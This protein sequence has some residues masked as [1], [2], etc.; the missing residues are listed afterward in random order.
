VRTVTLPVVLSPLFV[1]VALTLGLFCWMAYQRVTSIRS[2]TVHPRDIALREPN[3]PKHCLQVANAA[4][5]QLETPVLFY[6]LTILA[7]IAR[8]ADAL[9]VAL[10]W[11][12][13][14]LRLAHAYVHVTSNR[15]PLR[16]GVFGLGLAVLI[17]MWI[18][19]G[20]RI[21]LGSP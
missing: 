7:I 12:F 4:H 13:V 15:V 8:Q 10:S 17:V 11:V 18:V 2:G 20:A 6:V 16:G 14:L 3:W 5:N 21:L 1:Q 19:F 9:F